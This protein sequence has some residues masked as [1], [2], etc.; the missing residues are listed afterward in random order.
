MQLLRQ[1]V[2]G[3][4]PDILIVDEVHNF[5]IATEF[6][7]AQSKRVMKKTKNR[8][9]LVLMSATVDIGMLQDYFSSISR[10]IPVFDIP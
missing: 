2:S 8:M 10:D 4:L 5:S 3:I 9:K 7:I 1:T 6:L